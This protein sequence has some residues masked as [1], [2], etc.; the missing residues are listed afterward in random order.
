MAPAVLLLMPLR[1]VPLLPPK[2]DLLAQVPPHSA[3]GRKED[4]A[5]FAHPSKRRLPPARRE[6]ESLPHRHFLLEILPM[7]IDY[8]LFSLLQGPD[9]FEAQLAANRCRVD[10]QNI[11][12]GKPFQLCLRDVTVNLLVHLRNFGVR[13]PNGVSPRWRSEHRL[14][15][16]ILL[17]LGLL[18]RRR[19]GLLLLRPAAKT[20]VFV[21]WSFSENVFPCEGNLPGRTLLRNLLLNLEKLRSLLQ[22]EGCELLDVLPLD[23]Q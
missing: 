17:V 5:H 8:M 7:S 3:V 16:Q 21:G 22:F 10:L 11:P 2:E 14:L 12:L 23:V 4:V 20:C 18:A 6:Q 19:L 15:G 9:D 1:H 13:R